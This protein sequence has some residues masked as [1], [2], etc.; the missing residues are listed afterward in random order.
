MEE[1]QEEPCVSAQLW[2]LLQGEAEHGGAEA[3]CESLGLHAELAQGLA[4][5]LQVQLCQSPGLQRLCEP[6]FCFD[7]TGG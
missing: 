7:S 1:K 2:E 6:G 4:P 5:G 3:G